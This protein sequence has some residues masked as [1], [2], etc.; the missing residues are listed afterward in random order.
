MSLF[1]K[2]T[3][4]DSGETLNPFLHVFMYLT[5]IFGL[6]FLFGGGSATLQASVL[7]QQTMLVGEPWVNAWG[8][9]GVAVALLH[10]V[11]FLVRGKVGVRLMQACLFG[12]FYM[13][14]W[15][16]AIYLSGGFVFQF[17]VAVVPNLFFW[18]WYAFQWAKRKRGER[19]AFV[20]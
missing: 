10:T 8:L 16:G 2:F 3:K 13:W 20:H 12:G 7:F 14:C 18:S 11:A 19:V 15:A 6:A 17:L 9:I 4:C 5:L 1:D